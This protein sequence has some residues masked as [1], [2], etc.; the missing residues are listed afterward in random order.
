M[1]YAIGTTVTSNG[2][3][4]YPLGAGG[5]ISAGTYAGWA[6]DANEL[7]VDRL[8]R[9]VF[10]GGGN[11]LW[12]H[13]VSAADAGALSLA[14]FHLPDSGGYAGYYVGDIGDPH[15]VAVHPSLDVLYVSFSSK[16]LGAYAYDSASGALTPLGTLPTD[17]DPRGVAVHPDGKH[18]FVAHA[19][20]GAIGVYTLGVNG[21]LSGR[22]SASAAPAT[23][24]A[25]EPRAST[26]SRPAAPRSAAT[27][28]SPTEASASPA[29]PPAP[30][31][32]RATPTTS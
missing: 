28:S 13:R 17:V 31:R 6:N 21:S 32:A 29:R 10:V 18:L 26:S 23:A 27:R 1:L 19:T 3:Y 11:E 12:V 5:G 7:A 4:S 15:F 24:I 22:T 20:T 2:I 8:G 14:P 16:E 9:F 25:A 30:A